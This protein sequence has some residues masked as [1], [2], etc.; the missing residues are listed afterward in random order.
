MTLYKHSSF[1]GFDTVCAN[2]PDGCSM[3]GNICYVPDGRVYHVHVFAK[4][5]GETR[6]FDT[7]EMAQAWL[8]AHL[9]KHADENA[10]ILG[11]I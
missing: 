5:H 6:R 3:V 9:A 8:D 2:Y 11:I 1:P 7:L 10:R 4:K